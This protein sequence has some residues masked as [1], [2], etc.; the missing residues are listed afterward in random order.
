M[1]KFKFYKHVLYFFKNR[2]LFANEIDYFK[3]ANSCR[4]IIKVKTCVFI[5]CFNS[6]M[7]EVLII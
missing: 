6:S 3:T 5:S 2:W 4:T 1:E 7:V